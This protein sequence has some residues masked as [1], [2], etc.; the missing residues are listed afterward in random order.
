MSSPTILVVDDDSAL[1]SLFRSLMESCGWTVIDAESLATARSFLKSHEFQLALI[2]GVLPDGRGMELIVEISEEHPSL[3]IVFMSAYAIDMATFYKMVHKYHVSL[4]LK[5][6]VAPPQ[7][8]A[9]LRELL[10][11]VDGKESVPD[12]PKEIRV[13]E[14][15]KRVAKLRTEFVDV[16]EIRFNELDVAISS[17]LDGGGTSEFVKESIH[18]THKSRGSAGTYGFYDVAEMLGAMEKRFISIIDDQD[19]PTHALLTEAREILNQARITLS[20]QRPKLGAEVLTTIDAR[21]W[22]G[23]A[24]FVCSDQSVLERAVH[25]GSEHLLN[26][27]PVHSKEDAISVISEK[28]V[29]CVFLD[30]SEDMVEEALLLATTLRSSPGNGDLPLVFLMRELDLRHRVSAIHAGASRILGYPLNGREL[31]EAVT[32]LG[33]IRRRASPKVVLVDDD[34]T[35]AGFIAQILEEEGVIVSYVSDSLSTLEALSEVAPDL[36][37]CDLVMPGI[38]GLEL[39]RIVRASPEWRE[40]PILLMTAQYGRE[41]VAKAY[42]AGADDFFWKPILRAE[43]VARVRTRLERSTWTR[44][45]ANRDT[46]TGLLLPERFIRQFQRELE[47]V[48]KNEEALTVALIDVGGLRSMNGTHGHL[49]GERVLRFMGNLLLGRFRPNDLRCRWGGDEFVIVLPG[50]NQAIVELLLK[51]LSREVTEFCFH[52]EVDHDVELTFST[53]IATFPEAGTSVTELLDRALERLDVNKQR[54]PG[55]ID[56]SSRTDE[57]VG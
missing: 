50:L 30:V 55:H 25:I 12:E 24:I 14:M 40:L 57:R 1:R 7:I 44:Q 41:M 34:P 53:G 28:R 20:L 47:F 11:E 29:D 32:V 51:R 26:I 43:V 56:V 15:E 39:C 45:N 33:A 31:A 35:Q 21:E 48:T 19:G 13:S 4:V 36:L 18:I 23:T 54:G 46:L 27:I 5:K 16:L 22:R 8:L 38:G 17:A 6:P 49:F 2:D 3:K 37:I 10:E 9:H 52:G 42:E